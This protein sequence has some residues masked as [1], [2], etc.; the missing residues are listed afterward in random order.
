MLRCLHPHRLQ[1]RRLRRDRRPHDRVHRVRMDLVQSG[2]RL[3]V[4]LVEGIW[5][6]R[7]RHL[8]VLEHRLS[9]RLLACRDIALPRVRPLEG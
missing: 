8:V 6:H 4:G 1:G 9:G 2:V 3:E 5:H 7:R